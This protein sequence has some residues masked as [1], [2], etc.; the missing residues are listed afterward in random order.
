M[1]IFVL[2]TDPKLA[3]QDHC[4]K[5]VVKMI[6]ESAQ[7]LST[8]HYL[9]FIEEK[10]LTFS[11]FKSQRKITDFCRSA[12]H[13]FFNE[14]YSA[15]HIHHPCTQWT[16]K[17]TQ[18]YKWLSQ[19]AINLCEEYEKR[20]LKEHKCKTVINK[21]INNVPLLPNIG[22]T[23][24]AIAM[25]NEYKISSNPV[26]CY[27]NYYLKDKIRFAKWKYSTQPTWWQQNEN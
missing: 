10:N 15:S 3:A 27:R 11:D 18:N 17:S 21:L 20:Y 14:I 7:M 2:D 8:A 6:L 1:N 4:D 22:L 16:I 9:K 12:H 26:E 5:H 23:S 13:S 24:F 19:L 25:K